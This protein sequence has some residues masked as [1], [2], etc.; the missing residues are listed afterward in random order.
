ML[1][2]QA[3]YKNRPIGEIKNIRQ[4]REINS[5]LANLKWEVIL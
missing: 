2:Y 5:C 4:I 3:Y 1:M